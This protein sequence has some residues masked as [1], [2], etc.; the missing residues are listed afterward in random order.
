MKRAF[1]ERKGV[2]VCVCV[3]HSGTH[4]LKELSL[5]YTQTQTLHTQTTTAC[6]C[7]FLCVDKENKIRIMFVGWLTVMYNV[8]CSSRYT[9]HFQT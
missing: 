3:W 7:V 6:M 1:G 9:T 8:I 4:S 2:C 5:S